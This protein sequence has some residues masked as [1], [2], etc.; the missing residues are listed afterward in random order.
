MIAGSCIIDSNT[1]VEHSLVLT[2]TYVGAG[3]ELNKAIVDRDL[4]VNVE[5][6]TSINVFE[7][8]LL[9]G[10][11]QRPRQNWLVR[12][13][14]ALGAFLLILML[15]PISLLSMLYY[16]LTEHSFPTTI[17]IAELPPEKGFPPAAAWILPSMPWS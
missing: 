4:L 1:T 13:F 14:R 6:G 16:A 9:G 8:F 3:L 7:S 12:G 2:G 5:L 10:L 11:T 15:L 17:E